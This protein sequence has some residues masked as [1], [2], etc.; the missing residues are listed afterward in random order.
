MNIHQMLWV[1]ERK[2][3]IVDE[4]YS[5]IASDISDYHLL[6]LQGS[7]GW[8]DNNGVFITCGYCSHERLLDALNLDINNVESDLNW[9]R[10]SRGVFFIEPPN[11]AQAKTLIHLM[12]KGIIAQSTGNKLESVND[13]T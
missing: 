6:Y 1:R 11:E 7:Y 9:I 5:S 10:I 2:L 12:D 8:I 3:G 13:Y 4:G